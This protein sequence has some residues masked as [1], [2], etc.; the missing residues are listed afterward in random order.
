LS[1]LVSSESHESGLICQIQSFIIRQNT[2][3]QNAFK[4]P[5]ARNLLQF[6]HITPEDPFSQL[7]K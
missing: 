1:K 2:T 3:V 7:Q 6:T 5:L 4:S